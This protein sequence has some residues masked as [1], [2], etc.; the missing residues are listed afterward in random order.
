MNNTFADRP[1]AWL[2][3]NDASGSATL[4]FASGSQCFTYGGTVTADNTATIECV[5]EGVLHGNTLLDKKW[6][7]FRASF[8]P[9]CQAK[10]QVA[11]T[12]TFNTGSKN[13]IDLGDASSGI[14][15]KKFPE[16]SRGK[17]LFWKIYEASRNARFH[18]FGFEFDADIINK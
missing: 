11:I 8:N 7:W 16:G 6:N 10:I 2:S 14:V 13:W 18:F 15:E 4:A 1:R 12:N 17:F 3:Y 9:G 5:M